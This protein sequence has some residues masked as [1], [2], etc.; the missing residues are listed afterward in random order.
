MAT[1]IRK[2]RNFKGLGLDVAAAPPPEPEP[3]VMMPMPTRAAPG[4]AGKKRPPPMTLKAPKLP[5]STT[6]ASNGAGTPGDADIV[7]VSGVPPGSAPA[8]ASPDVSHK[9]MTYHTALSH[10]L[11]TLDLN[12]EKKF[13]LK[14][15]DDLRDIHELGQGNGGSV[16][17]VEHVPTGTIMAKKVRFYPMSVDPQLGPDGQSDRAHRRQAIGTEANPP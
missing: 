7:P 14:N 1:P 5:P 17:K 9:R 6:S 12:A 2:K 3:V 13:D 4:A 8:T 11:A 15:N 16:K 10:T